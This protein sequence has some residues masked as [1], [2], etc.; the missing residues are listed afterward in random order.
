[1]TSR[2]MA[3]VVAL[4][5]LAVPAVAETGASVWAPISKTAQTI[6]GSVTLAPGGITFQNGK[7]LPL[8]HGGQMLFRPEAKKKKVMADIY[9][10][11]QPENLVLEN[12][13]P[14]CKGKPATYLIVWKSAKLGNEVDPRTMAVFS[15]PRF[16]PG[17]ADE[18][19]RYAYD[20]GAH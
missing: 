3:V 20:A 8:G 17:S 15:G 5:G 2:R 9:R 13:N 14:L 11:T 7:S 10:I 18:C 19:G 1:M 6:T 4:S 16:D 12:G